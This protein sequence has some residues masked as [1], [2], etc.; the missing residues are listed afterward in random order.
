MG[1]IVL[2]FDDGQAVLS[3][4]SAPP[5]M[6]PAEPE[7]GTS[8]PRGPLAGTRLLRTPPPGASGRS[9]NIVKGESL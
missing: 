9:E 8:P 4:H 2:R 1:D 5:F 6:F 7:A 3:L